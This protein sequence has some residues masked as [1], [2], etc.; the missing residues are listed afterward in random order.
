MKFYIDCH[1]ASPAACCRVMT[2]MIIS[3]QPSTCIRALEQENADLIVVSALL[4]PTQQTCSNKD[5]A[6]AMPTK[7]WGS[8]HQHFLSRASALSSGR[9][10]SCHP[11]TF[12]AW[13]C[14]VLQ[15]RTKSPFA[16]CCAGRQT[17]REDQKHKMLFWL[18]HADSSDSLARASSSTSS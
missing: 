1:E 8:S 16:A 2:R 5:G 18:V 17:C 13:V 3:W 12:Q 10:F 15:K 14:K 7:A 6:T 4:C 11:N 9:T